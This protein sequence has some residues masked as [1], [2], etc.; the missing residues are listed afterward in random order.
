M[1]TYENEH[2][3]VLMGHREGSPEKKD[4]SN[5]GIPGKDRKNQC[6]Q[7]NAKS[8]TGGTTINKA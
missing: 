1:E 7:P 6:K 4:D 8:T 2:T 5:T 3:T